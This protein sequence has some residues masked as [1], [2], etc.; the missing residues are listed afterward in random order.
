[1][2]LYF[3]YK[4]MIFTIPQF[5]YAFLCAYSGTSIYDD[6]YISMYNLLFTSI[7]L[8]VW[9]ILDHDLYYKKWYKTHSNTQEK[10][11]VDQKCKEMMP[12]F[13][14]IS[15]R[16]LN[17][18][19]YTFLQW[20]VHGLLYALI[21]FT[22]HTLLI[23][24]VTMSSDGDTTDIWYVSITLYTTI[25][26]IVTLR[27]ILYTRFWTWISYVAILIFTVILYMIWLW[28]ADNIKF[29]QVY[30]TAYM[31]CTTWHGYLTALVC[32]WL[33][34]CIEMIFISFGS[35]TWADRYRLD[36]EEYH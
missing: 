14:Y 7:P 29:F 2:I 18:T 10:V 30:K 36:P 25:V 21:V 5:Y 20:I 35:R 33:I 22:I 26:A 15:Q 1:M 17:F 31:L 16:N 8:L 6:Y 13:Y 3:F 34:Y 4:N 32:L 9:A 12:Q 24:D 19:P 23:G 27:I 28:V 11:G